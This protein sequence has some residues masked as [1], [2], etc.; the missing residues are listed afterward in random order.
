M[1]FLQGEGIIDK[2]SVFKEVSDI[3]KQLDGWNRYEIPETTLTLNSTMALDVD[4][5]KINV[6]IN[7]PIQF[8]KSELK[9]RY[10]PLQN[11]WSGSKKFKMADSKK[12]CFSK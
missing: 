4:S 5:L 10:T 6:L 8:D 11:I 1:L 9:H 2:I 3:V 7:G 12:Q